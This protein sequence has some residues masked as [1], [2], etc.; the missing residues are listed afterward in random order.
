MQGWCIKD[1]IIFVIKEERKAVSQFIL[2]LLR[3]KS[4]FM[5]KERYF[6][7]FKGGVYK[8]ISIAYDSETLEELVVYQA[9]YGEK[10][11]W[12]RPKELFFSTVCRDGETKERFKEISK[13][14][15]L[16]LLHQGTA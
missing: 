2:L 10:R 4:N 1:V 11:T 3:H 9:L 6:Q 8:L 5:D 14:E 15:M 12:V 7:H 16:C 13:E